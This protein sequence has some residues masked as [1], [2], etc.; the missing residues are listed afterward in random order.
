MGAAAAL[1]LC[2]ALFLGLHLVRCSTGRLLP[3][4]GM[5]SALIAAAL[6][7]ARHFNG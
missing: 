5:I 6:T 1:F 7:V 4:L 3:F 2:T